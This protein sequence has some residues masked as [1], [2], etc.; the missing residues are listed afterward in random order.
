MRLYSITLEQEFTVQF[1]REIFGEPWT[2]K[3]VRSRGL[4][5]PGERTKRLTM[6]IL[7]A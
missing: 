6:P 5:R 2:D 1:L 3:R 7:P 4:P